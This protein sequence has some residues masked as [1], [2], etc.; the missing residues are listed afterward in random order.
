MSKLSLKKPA[1]GATWTVSETK[2]DHVESVWD[3]DAPDLITAHPLSDSFSSSNLCGKCEKHGVLDPSSRRKHRQEAAVEKIYLDYGTAFEVFGRKAC[4][5][6]RLILQRIPASTYSRHQLRRRAKDKDTTSKK[7]VHKCMLLDDGRSFTIFYAGHIYGLVEISYRGLKATAALQGIHVEE[8]QFW[9]VA[10]IDMGDIRR[11]LTSSIESE[12]AGNEQLPGGPR[13]PKDLTLI[14]VDEF[15]IVRASPQTTYVALSYVWGGVSALQLTSSNRHELETKGV[16]WSRRNEI[17]LLI[18]DAITFTARLK[19]R[20]LWVDALCIQQDVTA[21]A[22]KL[23]QIRQMDAIYNSAIVTL[24]AASSIDAESGLPGMRPYSRLSSDTCYSTCSYNDQSVHIYCSVSR[25]PDQRISRLKYMSRGWTFQELLISNRLIIFTDYETIF[26]SPE[27]LYKDPKNSRPNTRRFIQMEDDKVMG[28][29]LVTLPDI[30]MLPGPDT[31]HGRDEQFKIYASLVNEYSGRHLTFATD[32]LNAFA[33]II[34]ALERE[35]QTSFT[36]G[37][38]ER[39]LDLALL[40]IPFRTSSE[41]ESPGRRLV[42]QRRHQFPSWSWVGWEGQAAY[43]SRMFT[44]TSYVQIQRDF[45]KRQETR[46]PHPNFDRFRSCIELVQIVSQS[47]AKAVA[48]SDTTNEVIQN[49]SQEEHPTI[50]SYDLLHIRA[51]TISVSSFLFDPKM[52]SVFAAGLYFFS[53]FK[54]RMFSGEFLPIYDGK[55]RR[56]GFL[57]DPGIPFNFHA[58]RNKLI[59]MS[60]SSK[61]CM[62][63]RPLNEQPRNNPFKFLSP[64]FDPDEF[65]PREWCVL[66]VMLVRRS[67]KFWERITIGV[68]HEDAWKDAQSKEEELILG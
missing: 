25:N 18:Q 14:D 51:E 46:L 7:E 20:Y 34:A 63:R 32:G 36:N 42:R 60:A 68:V 41:R 56:C 3:L 9:K 16:L 19:E 24:V 10:T 39:M 53:S 2:E 65:W 49:A 11:W 1:H 55:N 8:P 45:V 66:N 33:G 13:R 6:C 47:P 57:Y 30:F 21:T 31:P 17:P 43:F 35:F 15:K 44:S 58:P 52:D 48:S 50:H 61:E 62:I 5:F 4:P 26:K 64:Y 23:D 29:Q 67:G 28:D 27:T 40:W 22:H 37:L 54:E 59:R 12:T 38:P